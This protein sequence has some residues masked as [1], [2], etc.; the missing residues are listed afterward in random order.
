MTSTKDKPMKMGDGEVFYAQGSYVEFWFHAYWNRVDIAKRD[1]IRVR[2]R[3]LST[4]LPR[5]RL[6]QREELREQLLRAEKRTRYSVE[7]LRIFRLF[8]HGCR[9][10][11]RRTTRGWRLPKCHVVEECRQ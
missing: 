2:A 9:I 10:F 4:Q 3:Q 11:W 1:R 8:S 5:L 6:R 7:V